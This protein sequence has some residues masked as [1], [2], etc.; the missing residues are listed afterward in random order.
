M[1]PA[2]MRLHTRFVVMLTQLPLHAH[3]QENKHCPSHQAAGC[4]Q[5]APQSGDARRAAAAPQPPMHG[6]IVIATP[7]VPHNLIAGSEADDRVPSPA[8]QLTALPFLAAVQVGCPCSALQA[9]QVRCGR[10]GLTEGAQRQQGGRPSRWA[11]QPAAGACSCIWGMQTTSLGPRS[12]RYAW[13]SPLPPPPPK[14]PH[15]FPL[16]AGAGFRPRVRLA[17]CSAPSRLLRACV[18]CSGPTASAPRWHTG[19]CSG[20]LPAAP[21]GG[22][23]T[24]GSPAPCSAARR[25]P[26]ASWSPLLQAKQRQPSPCCLCVSARRS[27]PCGCQ[28]CWR[29]G[30]RPSGKRRRSAA[31]GRLTTLMDQLLRIC[32]WAWEGQ[33]MAGLRGAGN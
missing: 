33:G 9:T 15:P 3:A 28:S 13:P 17:A 23:P 7:P 20:E 12:A 29:G 26:P 11:H 6:T 4:E 21:A 32:G 18:R 31:A 30:T 27:T 16:V 10:T 22:P 8:L 1:Q 24:R 5:P 14:P 2:C 25:G 19:S